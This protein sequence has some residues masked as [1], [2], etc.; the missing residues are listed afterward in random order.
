MV[1][2]VP[3]SGALNVYTRLSGS[4]EAAL[5]GTPRE[6]AD[7]CRSG[8]SS[9]LEPHGRISS[10]IR[11]RRGH[12]SRL[13][14]V[15]RATSTCIAGGRPGPS[16]NQLQHSPHVSHRCSIRDRSCRTLACCRDPCPS[17]FP[18]LPVPVRVGSDLA[19]G[20]APGS[21]HACVNLS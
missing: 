16:C 1:V 2:V 18:P 9:S 6:N 5:A 7:P 21:Q 4:F 10:V 17:P 13:G 12:S 15:Q 20:S 11:M 14:L 3:A 19:E 8:S